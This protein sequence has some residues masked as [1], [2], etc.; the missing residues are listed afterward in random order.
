MSIFEKNNTNT[1]TVIDIGTTKISVLVAQIT[2]DGGIL[3]KGIGKALCD[4][5]KKGVVVDVAKTVHAISNA[6]AEAEIMSNSHIEQAIIGISGSHIHAHN[7]SGVVPIKTG[8]IS[9]TDI[10]NALAAAQAIALDEGQQI[11]HLL[12]RYFRI[13]NKDIVHDP[14]NMHGIRL[15]VEAYIITGATSSIKNLISCCEQANIQVLDIILEQIASAHA[16]LSPDERMLGALVIDIGGGTSDVAL[17]HNKTLHYTQ[18]VPIAGNQFTHDLAIGL[19][20]TN[21]TAEMIKKEY[22]IVYPSLVDEEK[23][24][25]IEQVQGND[26]QI[27]LHSQLYHILMPRAVELLKIIKKEITANHLERYMNTGII[28][29]GGG[30]LLHGMQELT[31]H[32]FKVPVR[33]GKPHIQFTLPQ[34]INSP[35]FATG[36]GMLVYT[37]YKQQYE[38]TKKAKFNPTKIFERMKSWIT[39]LF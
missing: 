31:E 39:D 37:A 3:I 8:T 28:L 35:I 9:K 13:D 10:H 12:P 15:E 26:R 38:L 33:I 19:R 4:G 16:V 20:T 27:V 2:S 34:T 11:L 6:V 29:T 23:L 17:Y 5:L 1:I 22:G 24:I 30:S 7:S 36:Y 21:K 18:V 32:L 14:L 25:E